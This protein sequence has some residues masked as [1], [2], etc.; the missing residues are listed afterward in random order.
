YEDPEPVFDEIAGLT[1]EKATRRMQEIYKEPIKPELITKRIRE[2]KDAGVIA[3]ASLT[4]QRVTEYA[5]L[6]LEAE[7]DIF[8]IQGTVVSGEHVSSRLE[9]LNLKEFIPNFD[10]PVIVGGCAS[11]STALRCMR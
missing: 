10:I 5:S 9:P 1:D 6:V 3:A 2:I 4:P 11:D 8:V 7:L